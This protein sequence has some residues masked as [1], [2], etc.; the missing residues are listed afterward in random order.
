MKNVIK[1]KN[2]C[3]PK[4]NYT[5]YEKNVSEKIVY[6][7]KIYKFT[8]EHF[9]IRHVVFIL[10]VKNVIKNENFHFAPN[11]YRIRKKCSELKL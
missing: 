4:K 7:K 10:I 11:L 9:L 1:N 8:S 2:F 6:L 3:F 5:I